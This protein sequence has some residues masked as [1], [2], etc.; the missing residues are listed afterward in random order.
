MHLKD[1]G[2]QGKTTHKIRR[3]EMTKIGTEVKE[4]DKKKIHEEI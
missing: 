2:K 1:L 3:K 4:T